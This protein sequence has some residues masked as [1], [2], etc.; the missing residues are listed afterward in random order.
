MEIIDQK[1]LHDSVRW[2]LSPLYEVRA[3]PGEI[4]KEKSAAGDIVIANEDGVKKIIKQSEYTTNSALYTENGYQP[5][6][7]V[8]VP[9]LHTDDGTARCMSLKWMTTQSKTGS[10]NCFGIYWGASY[11]CGTHAPSAGLNYRIHGTTTIA[12]YNS[13]STGYA[14]FPSNC[15]YWGTSG[16]LTDSL[17]PGAPVIRITPGIS[18]YDV[19]GVSKNPDWFVEGGVGDYMDGKENTAVIISHVNT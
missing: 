2:P 8:V 9:A 11:N 12:K 18:P 4:T 10:D 6:A 14:A 19:D 13:N 17:D 15:A 7:V 1:I 5:I 3:L 16:N